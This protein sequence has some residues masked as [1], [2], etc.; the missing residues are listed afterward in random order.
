MA[1]IRLVEIRGFRSIKSLDWCPLEGINC[2]VGPGDSGKSTILDAIEVCLSPRK[3]LSFSDTDFH[4]L[5]ITD[6]VRIR[7]TL[8]NL[9]E[10]LRD[11]D[12][13]GELLRSFDEFTDQVEDEPRK[14]LETV[15]TVELLVQADLEPEWRLFS[16]RTAAHEPRPLP[17]K[18]RVAMA[19]T[20]LGSHPSSHLSWNRS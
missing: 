15:L 14:G 18:D 6:P 4:D 17:W 11:L 3:S 16:E 12:T 5:S 20:R 9:P 1:S 13:Y 7:V 19:P 2:L 8:G 10:H